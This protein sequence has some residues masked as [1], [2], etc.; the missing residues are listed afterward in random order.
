VNIVFPIPLAFLAYLVWLGTGQN[1]FA[2]A[3]V[4]PLFVAAMAAVAAVI[5]GNIA[6][7]SMQFSTSMH[8]IV[9]RHQMIATTV[10]ILS[11]ILTAVRIWRW[12][13]IAGRWRWIYGGGL[14]VVSMLLGITGYLGGSL[15]FGPDHLKW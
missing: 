6:H 5:T 8:E 15:V 4:P 13:T 1:A 9:E 3:D 12:N 11:L 7:D 14:F 2:K 10:M